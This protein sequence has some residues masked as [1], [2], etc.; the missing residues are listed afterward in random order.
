M[1]DF[2]SFLRVAILCGSAVFAVAMTL[3]ALPNSRL[4]LVGSECL[5]YA[6]AAALLVLAPSPVDFVPDV[7]P[8]LGWVD[9]LGYLFGAGLAVKSGLSDR[10]QRQFEVACENALLAR[11][12]GVDPSDFG[13]GGDQ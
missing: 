13:V 2:F 9:D 12:A 3:L 8:L 5:K 1:S 11:A 6:G 10:R 7:V 4:R